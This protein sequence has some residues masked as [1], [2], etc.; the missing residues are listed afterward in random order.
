M[1]FKSGLYELSIN[2]KSNGD[3]VFEIS[4]P[5]SFMG[6]LIESEV[7]E[8]IAFNLMSKTIAAT[9]IK[10]KKWDEHVSNLQEHGGV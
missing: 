6:I 10:A 8:T 2:T 5:E 3:T 1:I 9:K 4:D 7:V